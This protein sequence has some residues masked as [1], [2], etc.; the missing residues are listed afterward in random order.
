VFKPTT[1]GFKPPVTAV[2]KAKK[3]YT[4]NFQLRCVISRPVTAVYALQSSST[5]Q[6][7]TFLL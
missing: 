6:P 7:Q 3:Q 5:L 1:Y 2:S 4:N